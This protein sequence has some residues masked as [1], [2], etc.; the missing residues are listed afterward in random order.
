MNFLPIGILLVSKGLDAGKYFVLNQQRC[1]IGRDNANDLA[2]GDATV[3]RFHAQLELR[4][5][6]DGAETQV[7]LTDLGSANG[8]ELNGEKVQSEPL[9]HDDV[10]NL[11][12]VEIIFKR[13]DG[14]D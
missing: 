10:I 6:A 13:L 5:G 3:S 1:H 14:Q 4:A 12:R 11:G 8:T 2:L 9:A 7:V